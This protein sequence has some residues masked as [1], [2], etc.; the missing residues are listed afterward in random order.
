MTYRVQISYRNV[1]PSGALERLIR[2]EAAKLE[3]FFERITSCHV[4]I[5]QLHRRRA[6]GSPFHVRIELGVPGELLVV[7]HTADVRPLFPLNDEADARFRPPSHQDP[8][9][10][11][12]L[13]IRQA[14]H[15]LERQLQDF[16]RRKTGGVR[17]REPVSTAG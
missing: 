2:D 13:A 11:P 7:S 14:F 3:R 17:L 1:L 5:E 12:K 16:A 15:K 4:L 9:K 8:A 10:D 6:D